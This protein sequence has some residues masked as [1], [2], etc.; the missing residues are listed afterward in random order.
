MSRKAWMS[1]LGIY[2]YDNTIWDL[3]VLPENV[4]KTL[5][6]NKIMLDTSEL[7]ILYPNPS[8][9]KVAI[10]L[11]SQKNLWNWTELEKTLHYDYDPIENYNRTETWE[12][13]ENIDETSSRTLNS[14]ENSSG[15]T[16]SERTTSE[17][18]QNASFNDGLKDVQKVDTT[19]NIEEN[20]TQNATNEENENDNRNNKRNKN[21]SGNA[22][23]NIGVMTTQEMIEAQRDV[24]KFNIY[25]YITSS[26]IDSFC[27]EVY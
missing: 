27:I 19:D 1:I 23:G 26:F 24:L 25:D 4:D 16:T 20:V 3:M 2:N 13:I 22:R 8:I 6:T 15:D 21:W 14:T 7:E 18:T 5:L 17:T 10:Q 11:W 12:E 9:L